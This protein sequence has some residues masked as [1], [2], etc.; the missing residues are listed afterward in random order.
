MPERTIEIP[1]GVEVSREGKTLAVK[2]KKGSLKRDF[3]HGKIK[4]DVKAKQIVLASQENRRKIKATLGTWEAIIKNMVIGVSRGWRCDMKLVF[5][6]FPAKMSVKDNEFSIQNFLGERA[7]RSAK[8]L[9][10]VNI[11]IDKENIIISG[12]D[13]EKVGLVAGKIEHVTKIVGY[14]RRIFQDGC[15]IV[16]HAYPEN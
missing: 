7:A 5:S 9:E 10:D 15:F 13:K 12:I 14:D 3:I 11:K 4:I 6:H 2:G 16:K 8:M 1:D